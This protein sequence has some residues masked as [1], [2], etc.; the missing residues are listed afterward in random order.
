MLHGYVHRL[1]REIEDLLFNLDF[2][3]IAT[4][5][6][7]NKNIKAKE[8]TA[9]KMNVQELSAITA[10]LGKIYS[11][12]LNIGDDR[13]I[14]DEE[15][16]LYLHDQY[17]NLRMKVSCEDN[18]YKFEMYAPDGETRTFYFDD[19][20]NLTMRGVFK[21]GEEG[22]ERFEINK[23][24]LFF[25][26]DVNQKEGWNIEPSS[27]GGQ[28]NLYVN[29]GRRGSM[30]YSYYDGNGQ[31]LN[32]ILL[33][34]QDSIDLTGG[35]KAILRANEIHLGSRVGDA[36]YANGERVATKEWVQSLIN[37]AIQQHLSDHH[38]GA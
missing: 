26:D 28:L 35:W 1:S 36:I 20:G 12:Y 33:E 10:D 32:C 24:G 27:V 23:N 14:V 9:D 17:G 15:G 19:N 8:I 2:E 5:G 37:Q 16:N 29:N 22:E 11:G 13:F 34:T 30:K 7:R 3:N 6:I 4:N 38:P 21:T 25:K 31:N 18:T